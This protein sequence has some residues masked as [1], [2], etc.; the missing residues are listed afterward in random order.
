MA[1]ALKKKIPISVLDKTNSISREI[2]NFASAICGSP[3]KKGIIQKW[4]PL[5]NIFQKE[6][7]NREIL[8]EKYYESQL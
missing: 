3:E 8:R 1:E 7:V 4:I 6:K 2:E 5:K